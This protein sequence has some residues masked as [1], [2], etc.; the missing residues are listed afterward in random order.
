MFCK[1]RPLEKHTQINQ[2]SMKNQCKFRVG[3]KGNKMA[4]KMDLG[5]SWAQF[6]RGLRRSWGPFGHFWPPLGRFGGVRNQAFLKHWSKMGSNRAFGSTLGGSWRVW[7]GFWEGFGK[8]LGRFG[9]NLRAFWVIL[10]LCGLFWA[11]GVFGA[12]FRKI[13]VG[14][15]C[16]NG[17]HFEL[18]L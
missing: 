11:V 5:R 16:C 3:K 8:V 18:K 7:G 13:L 2:K 10:S 17:I 6:G 1:G 9:R 14:A 12:D 15:P 4:W